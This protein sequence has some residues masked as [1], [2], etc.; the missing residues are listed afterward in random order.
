M[1]LAA[2]SVAK[3]LGATVLA[4]TRR[5]DRAQALLDHGADHV[6]IDDGQ[7]ADEV[8]DLL[9]PGVDAALELVGAPTLP[10]TLRATRVHGTVCF[11]G[12]LSNRWTV[13]DFYPIDYLPTGVRL[14]GYSGGS[15]DL[16]H[17][18]S[19]AISTV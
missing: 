1:G 14:T 19:P 10:D 6:I 15:A 17:D 4:T 11:T 13:P 3:E 5:Q 8:H 16:P 2:C 18:G 9:G 12:M 7:V